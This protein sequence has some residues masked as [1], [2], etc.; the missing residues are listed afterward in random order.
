[1]L[2]KDPAEYDRLIASLDTTGLEIIWYSPDRFNYSVLDDFLSNP[3]A[4]GQ[5]TLANMHILSGQIFSHTI[6]PTF[7]GIPVLLGLMDVAWDRRRLRREAF[8]LTIVAAPMLS[9]LPFHIEI[10]FFAPAFPVLLMWTA[11]G[12]AA[13]GR[14]VVESW[15]CMQPEVG[16]ETRQRHLYAA[17]SVLPLGLV[18]VYFCVVIP[19]VVLSGQRSLD[20]THK[21]AGLW[22]RQ[23]A[24]PD[25]T[26]MT[27]DLAIAVY[28]QRPWIPSPNADYDHVMVYA[29][30][31]N[32]DYFVID[33]NEIT[34]LRPQLGP[35]LNEQDPP[36]GLIYQE[37]FSNGKRRTI[38]YRIP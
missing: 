38:I 32:A 21:D 34:T 20:W 7:L 12:L 25:A 17:L 15:R 10:R 26:I 33:E 24:A 16:S 14:W 27:R 13:I 31:H 30:Y 11:H 5:R 37:T 18:L 29:R 28:A 2:N 19:T 3:V 6:F 36:Q 4:F 1:V 23:H 22:L 9:F 35:L 8:L